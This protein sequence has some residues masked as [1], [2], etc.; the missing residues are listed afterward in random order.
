MRVFVYS[1]FDDA[2]RAYLQQMLPADTELIFNS[3][4]PLVQQEAAFQTAE[5]LQTQVAE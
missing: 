1:A 2:A 5:I 4:L 3:D